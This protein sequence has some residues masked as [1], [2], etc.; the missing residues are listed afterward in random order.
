MAKKTLS[1]EATQNAVGHAPKKRVDP[2]KAPDTYVQSPEAQKAMQLRWSPSPYRVDL[3]TTYRELKARIGK[4][5]QK[6]SPS[7]QKAITFETVKE[8]G[9]LFHFL[10]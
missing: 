8:K 6:R 9:M 10:P 1:E 7:S 3:L 5:K 2:I 4:V